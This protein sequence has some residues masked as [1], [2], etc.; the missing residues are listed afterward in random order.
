MNISIFISHDFFKL[1]TII[2]RTET[3]ESYLEPCE[4]SMNKII[5]GNR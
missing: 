2:L 1:Q 4:T 3:K 5:C